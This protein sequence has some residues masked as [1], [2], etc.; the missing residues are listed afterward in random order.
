MTFGKDFIDLL[1]THKRLPFATIED[2]MNT[3]NELEQ[4]ANKL[5]EENKL[6]DAEID[7]KRQQL[8]I[9]Q[10]KRQRIEQQKEAVEQYQS[11]LENVR[12]QN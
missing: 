5:K 9:L 11:F 6:R 2:A 12:N 3:V 1:K 7:R 10:A 4:E 8:R